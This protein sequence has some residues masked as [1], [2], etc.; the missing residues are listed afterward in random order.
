VQTSCRRFA[1]RTV[2]TATGRLVGNARSP[3]ALIVSRG[4]LPCAYALSS[5][6]LPR[7][8]HTACATLLMIPEKPRRAEPLRDAFRLRQEPAHDLSTSMPFR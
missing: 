8:V 2:S 3:A 1:G 7:K 5:R 6:T 4:R